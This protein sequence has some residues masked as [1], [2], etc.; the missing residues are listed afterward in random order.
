MTR[1]GRLLEYQ[2]VPG[3]SN[4]SR[5][6]VI[7]RRDIGCTRSAGEASPCALTKVA[8]KSALHRSG[9]NV[10]AAANHDSI[11]ANAI[12]SENTS[13]HSVTEM[14]FLILAWCHDREESG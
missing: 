3:G 11:Q 8:V 5:R 10:R 7:C 1:F 13:K 14:F 4:N 2:S 6:S 12:P 9:K